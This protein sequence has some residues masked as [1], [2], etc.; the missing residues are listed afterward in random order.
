MRAIDQMDGS[1]WPCRFVGLDGRP[2]ARSP[3]EY[4][5]SYD[6]F[7]LF[8]SRS[9]RPDDGT[10]YSDR[11]FQRDPALFRHCMAE[12][13]PESPESQSFSRMSSKDA[14]KFLSLYVG[15]PVELTAVLQGCN[16]SDGN[17][18]WVFFYKE[19]NATPISKGENRHA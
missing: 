8:R 12:T 4:H 16:A 14:E 1:G 6:E 11:L 19:K 15:R 9:F 2:V 10:E 3:H 13:A 7:V 17:P 18:Y 5:Y